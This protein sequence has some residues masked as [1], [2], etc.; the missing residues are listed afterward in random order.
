M[1]GET[2]EERESREFVENI[3]FGAPQLKPKRHNSHCY[4][5]GK[6]TGHVFCDE[7]RVLPKEVRGIY[8]KVVK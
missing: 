6:I 1:K 4:H 7:C 2:R 3:I 8:Y 5:C